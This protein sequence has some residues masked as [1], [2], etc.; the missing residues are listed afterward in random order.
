MGG[1]IRDFGGRT[2]RKQALSVPPQLATAE[3]KPLHHSFLT[4]PVL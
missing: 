4:S 2:N 1:I 3:V